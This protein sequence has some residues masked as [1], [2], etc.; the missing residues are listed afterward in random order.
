MKMAVFETID[1]GKIAVCPNAVNLC[2]MEH[3][4]DLC[5]LYYN[6]ESDPDVSS[7]SVSHTFDEAVEILNEAMN[8]PI[9]GD[10]QK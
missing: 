5:R 6:G 10:D 2:Y 1:G 7:V 4:P 9:L 3:E 8:M